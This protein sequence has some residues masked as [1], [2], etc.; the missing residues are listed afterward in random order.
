MVR[1]NKL[2]F[3]AAAAV[4][5]SL[6]LG[7]AISTRLW[8]EEREAR[9]NEARQ[10]QNA[11]A[12]EKNSLAQAER[13]DQN[14]ANAQAAAL[15]ARNTL[16]AADFL[17]AAKLTREGDALDALA[18][19][20]RSLSLNPSNDTALIRLTTLL[21]YHAWMLPIF[22]LDHGASVKS[23]RF[24][25]DGR[26]ILTISRIGTAQ[27]WDAQTCLPRTEPRRYNDTTFSMRDAMSP[28]EFSPDEKRIA[29]V[30]GDTARVWDAQSGQPVT[31]PLKHS[32]YVYSA[33]F[34]PDG[35]RLV[36]ASWDKTARVWDAQTGQP[37]SERLPPHRDVYAA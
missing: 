18:Y 37:L 21:S 5:V 27:V 19:L 7:L 23:A 4:S 26:R 22:M 32:G 3:T 17:Q 15:E 11:E 16:A 35:K 28:V 34:S 12:A 24:S 20:H 8:V 36:T 31:E 2:V 33:R 10:R 25:S 14:A 29:T 1:R 6:I 13:A 9:A 30:S